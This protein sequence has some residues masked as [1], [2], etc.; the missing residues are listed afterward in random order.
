MKTTISLIYQ[1][2]PD[3]HFLRKRFTGI[4]LVLAL[5]AFGGAAQ[6]ELKTDWLGPDAIKCPTGTE[7]KGIF[8]VMDIISHVSLRAD[9]Q[10]GKVFQS[11]TDEKNELYQAAGTKPA[12]APR[13][14]QQKAF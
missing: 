7:S 2:F 1:N 10:M 12:R 14:L 8:D 13:S 6:A 3:K 9:R 11:T 4:L 5:T